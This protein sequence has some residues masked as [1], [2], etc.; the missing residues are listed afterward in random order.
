MKRV[1]G[2]LLV[3]MALVLCGSASAQVFPTL[4]FVSFDQPSFTY[5]Y[6]ITCPANSTFPFGR[7]AILAEVPNAGM[8]FPWGHGADTD[9]ASRWT[10]YVQDRDYDEVT[11]EPLT[12]NAIW[13]A[14]VLEDVIPANM[15]WTGQFMLT[16]PNSR[17][18]DGVGITMDGGDWSENATTVYVPGPALIPEPSSIL[19]LGGL[20]AGLLPLIRRRR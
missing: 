10:F 4:E 18:V 1:S 13:K 12:S 2:A 5:T 15:A 8:Y 19:A 17:K 16:V 11:W 20:A 14:T 6:R 9:P 3:L 7:L